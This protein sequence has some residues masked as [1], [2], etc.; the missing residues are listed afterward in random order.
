ML[1]VAEH[2]HRI[3]SLEK[4]EYNLAGPFGVLESWHSRLS[5]NLHSNDISRGDGTQLNAIETLG[6]GLTVSSCMSESQGR[7][8]HVTWHEILPD[9]FR[10]SS[11][12]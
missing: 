3:L 1:N 7:I 10:S 9:Y 5:R 8:W 4:Q 6:N 12:G 2:T 11:H